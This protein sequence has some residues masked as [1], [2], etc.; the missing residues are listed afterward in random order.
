MEQPTRLAVLISGRGSNMK[1]IVAACRDGR[2]PARVV[3]VVSNLASAQGI[4]WAE[5]NGLATAVISH[6]DF[7]S[8]EVIFALPN[9][10]VLYS[11]HGPKTTVGQEKRSNPWTRSRN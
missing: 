11:G 7:S 5:S 3:L 8:R 10:T 6:K 2:L 9:E 1:S 4:E